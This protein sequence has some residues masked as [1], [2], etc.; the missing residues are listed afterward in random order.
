MPKPQQKE[1][2]APII[3]TSDSYHGMLY[4]DDGGYSGVEILHLMKEIKR[5]TRQGVQRR[6]QL[7]FEGESL[8]E[9]NKIKKFCQNKINLG[10]NKYLPT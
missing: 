9:C 6:E 5:W 4:F 3:G 10:S 7:C 1:I 2:P 8:C